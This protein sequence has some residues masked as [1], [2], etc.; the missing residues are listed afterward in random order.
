MLL[1]LQVEVGIGESARAPVLVRDDI[2]LLG[3][4]AVM[5]GSAPG[6]LAEHQPFG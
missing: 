2:A 6:V 5:E 4:E 3:L 1:E